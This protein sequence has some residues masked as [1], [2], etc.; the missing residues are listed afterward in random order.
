MSG[1]RASLAFVRSHTFLPCISARPRVSILLSSGGQRRRSSTEWQAERT[2]TAASSPCFVAVAALAVPAAVIASWWYG[3]QRTDSPLPLPRALAAAGVFVDERVRLHKAKS[4]GS[5]L[6]V[7][8]AIPSG[9]VLISVPAP[10]ILSGE[11]ARSILGMENLDPEIALCALLAEA[12]RE[13]EIGNDTI[14]LLEYML[15]LPDSFPSLPF[16]LDGDELE[17]ELRGTALFPA[18]RALQIQSEEERSAAVDALGDRLQAVWS[19][20]RWTWAKAVILTRAGPS[21]N[22][23]LDVRD[24]AIIPLIDF[25]NCDAVNPAAECQL[26]DSGDVSLVTRRPLH[27]GDEVTLSY[28]E[29]NQEELLFTFGFVLPG[30]ETDTTSPLGLESG[31]GMSRL[32]AGLLRLLALDRQDDGGKT[33]PAARLLWTSEASNDG[34][35]SNVDVSELWSAANLLDMSED[36]LRDVA[37]EVARSNRLPAELGQRVSVPAQRRLREMLH[38][39]LLEFETLPSGEVPPRSNRCKEFEAIR[40]YRLNSRRL[41]E[42]ALKRLDAESASAPVG[43]V[44]GVTS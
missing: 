22:I 18:A 27:G 20:E 4:K 38:A 43:A 15:K 6:F 29:Q 2:L 16:C 14:G 25:A 13:A 1:S 39:W 36:E 10:A 24:S 21:L 23:A 26:S 41:V 32:R 44:G 31:P 12:R 11:L 7:S 3:R 5:G 17:K 30:V 37:S 34:A 19:K 33:V 35:A 9:T 8:K 28:G 40:A 42:A